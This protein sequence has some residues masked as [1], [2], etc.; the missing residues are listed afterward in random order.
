MEAHNALNLVLSG[1]NFVGGDVKAVR[2][3]G[4]E[5]GE[6]RL[7]IPA[8]GPLEG[9]VAGKVQVGQLYQHWEPVGRYFALC[10][11]EVACNPLVPPLRDAEEGVENQHK[12]LPIYIK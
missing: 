5:R 12:T 7:E 3:G 8:A 1:N 9:R 6:M 10:V 2:V 4:G 11:L